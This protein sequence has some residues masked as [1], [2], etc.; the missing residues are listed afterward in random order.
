MLAIPTINAR[1][2][3]PPQAKT[4]PENRP[5]PPANPQL[6]KRDGSFCVLLVN[7]GRIFGHC[8]HYFCQIIADSEKYR[9]FAH[10]FK[11]CN[12][13]SSY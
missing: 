12:Y 7:N 9:I 10:G 6:H 4:L 2:T 3:L 11:S 5:K 1:K 13:G 8:P